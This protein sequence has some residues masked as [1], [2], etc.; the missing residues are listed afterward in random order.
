MNL[1]NHHKGGTQSVT[2]Y[3]QRLFRGGTTAIIMSIPY[4]KGAE[5]IYEENKKSNFTICDGTDQ[6]K[7][8]EAE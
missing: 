7:D 8:N 1:S 4:R 3:C 6:N 5:S 2:T